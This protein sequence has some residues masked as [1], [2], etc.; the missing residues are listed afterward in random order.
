MVSGVPSQRIAALTRRA[1]VLQAILGV[2]YPTADVAVAQLYGTGVAHRTAASI[3]DMLSK[4]SYLDTIGT[5]LSPEQMLRAEIL[6]AG[7][8]PSGYN[9]IAGRTAGAADPIL[10]SALGTGED[11]SA[12]IWKIKGNTRQKIMDDIRRGILQ[13]KSQNQIALDLEKHMY[14]KWRP[15]RD[16][17][18]KITETLR[19]REQVAKGRGTASYEARRLV[20]TE[21][22]AAHSAIVDTSMQD[23]PFLEGVDWLVA[24]IHFNVHNCDEYAA[25]SPYDITSHP[26]PPAHPNCMCRLS[27]R[28]AS[29]YAAAAKDI[30]A[31]LEAEEEADVDTEEA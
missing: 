29:G 19:P 22:T 20:R 24:G 11:L 6:A 12:T 18:G 17:A 30:A 14:A 10:K 5:S 31:I 16:A 15:K 26:S 21:I 28:Y 2:S 9:F 25:G 1:E 23:F 3:V 4:I 27:I 8:L 7:K 13:G